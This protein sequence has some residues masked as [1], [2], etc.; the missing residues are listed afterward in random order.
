M[1]IGLDTQKVIFA[2]RGVVQ[3]IADR[4]R[5]ETTDAE[6]KHGLGGFMRDLQN[7][8]M[9][10][11]KKKRTLDEIS[12]LQ[13]IAGK[14]GCADGGDGEAQASCREISG[15][16]RF[17]FQEGHSKNFKREVTFDW[18]LGTK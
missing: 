9:T 4:A 13:G 8:A 5:K 12:T 11:T 1:L 10:N 3:K 16:F 15:R 18:F 14:D 7:K 17:K 2:Q 6:V